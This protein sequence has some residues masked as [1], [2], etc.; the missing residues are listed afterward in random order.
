M[1]HLSV[2]LLSIICKLLTTNISWY[3]ST[4]KITSVCSTL[5]LFSPF[6]FLTW[7]VGRAVHAWPWES[8]WWGP[9]SS[10]SLQPGKEC[11]PCITVGKVRLQEIMASIT[12]VYLKQGRRLHIHNPILSPLLQM[13]LWEPRNKATR[14]WRLHALSAQHIRISPL[15]AAVYKHGDFSWQH[16]FLVSTDCEIDIVLTWQIQRGKCCPLGG[17]CLDIRV[18]RHSAGGIGTFICMW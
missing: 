12:T 13:L 14:I 9:S 16:T 6:H 17:F 2:A 5:L 1:K 11:C 15:F 3:W 18:L 4:V 8:S 7:S 10:P